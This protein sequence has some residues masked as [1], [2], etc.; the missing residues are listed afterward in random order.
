MIKSKNMYKFRVNGGIEALS[1][2]HGHSVLVNHRG[3]S[4]VSD[5]VIR[6][7]VTSGWVMKK[8]KDWGKRQCKKRGWHEHM[9]RAHTHCVFRKR[10]SCLVGVNV[11]H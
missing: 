1:E 4:D 11:F 6:R 2:W 8:R 5:P 10:W 9:S 7:G 3:Q